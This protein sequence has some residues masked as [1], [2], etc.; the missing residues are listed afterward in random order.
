MSKNKYKTS[1][2][3]NAKY[4]AKGTGVNFPAVDP[5]N[6]KMAVF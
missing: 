4:R 3:Q 1:A 6:L 5:P 2:F